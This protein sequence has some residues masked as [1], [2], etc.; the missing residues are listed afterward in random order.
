MAPLKCRSPPG[1]LGKKTV[2]GNDIIPRRF[3]YMGW[4]VSSHGPSYPPLM[5]TSSTTGPDSTTGRDKRD[6][7]SPVCLESTLRASTLFRITQPPTVT[8]DL[9]VTPSVARTPRTSVEVCRTSD[10]SPCSSKDTPE[11]DLPAE[12][13]S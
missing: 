6:S 5:S 10:P 3:K 2:T 11:S 13:Q 8:D 7:V 1:L 9:P 12:P 4:S